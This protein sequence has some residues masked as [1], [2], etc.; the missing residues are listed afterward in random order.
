MTY[1]SNHSTLFVYKNNILLDIFFLLSLNRFQLFVNRAFSTSN[2]PIRYLEDL[3]AKKN[4]ICNFETLKPKKT[5]RTKLRSIIYTINN[6]G[7]YI[8]SGTL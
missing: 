7:P 6:L 3:K 1:V 4:I 5:S 8:H 2:W